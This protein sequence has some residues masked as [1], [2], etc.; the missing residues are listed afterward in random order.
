VFLGALVL[1]AILF[2]LAFSPEFNPELD[3]LVLPALVAALTLYVWLP[4]STA[5]VVC[6]GIRRFH[7]LGVSG[8]YIAL[9][10]VPCA[11]VVAILYLLLAPGETPTHRTGDRATAL[12]VAAEP[13]SRK[14]R[15]ERR[16]TA[17]PSPRNSSGQASSSSRPGGPPGTPQ[18][19]RSVNPRSLAVEREAR[20]VGT[21][22][23][24]LGG[25]LAVALA[26]IGTFL[27]QRA[28]QVEYVWQV[29]HAIDLG[30]RMVPHKSWVRAES[31]RVMPE[32]CVTCYRYDGQPVGSYCGATTVSAQRYDPIP[33]GCDRLW[34]V[35]GRRSLRPD[36]VDA[37]PPPSDE[38]PFARMARRALE[39]LPPEPTRPAAIGELLCDEARRDALDEDY[40]AVVLLD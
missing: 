32:N 35:V 27:T 31:C 20:G 11:N 9:A 7:D 37:P 13:R 28:G 36:E 17:S 10:L 15:I 29:S 14:P 22:L 38:N 4:V 24:L 40:W 39:K 16:R 21:R 12:T 2:A 8:W 25:V 23:I 34:V 30:D 33:A 18:G 1:S 26:G 3:L 19:R 5:L 6:A